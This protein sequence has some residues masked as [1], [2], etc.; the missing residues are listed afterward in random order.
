MGAGSSSL[1]GC[2]FSL[3]YNNDC[4]LLPAVGARPLLSP[5]ALAH[6]ILSAVLLGADTVFIPI[7]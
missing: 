2:K 5:H 6:V 3:F 1:V 7:D 4:P